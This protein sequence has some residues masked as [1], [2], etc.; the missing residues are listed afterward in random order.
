MESHGQVSAPSTNADI[1]PFEVR[2]M[3]SAISS[4]PA[5]MEES[6]AE[7]SACA[8]MYGAAHRGELQKVVEWLRKGVHVDAL[9][10]F[11]DEDD[12]HYSGALHAAAANGQLAVI[13]EMLKWGASV[14]LPNSIGATPLMMAAA[15]CGHEPSVKA[16]L[17]ANAN[18]ELRESDGR[19]ALQLA[20][21]EG[22][23][24]IAELI[25]QHSSSPQH[26]NHPTLPSTVVPSGGVAVSSSASS[27]L[28]PSAARDGT[29]WGLTL[30]QHGDALSLLC[31]LVCL[32]LAPCLLLRRRAKRQGDSKKPK[33]QYRYG[34]KKKAAGGGSGSAPPAAEPAKEEARATRLEMAAA[35]MLAAEPRLPAPHRPARRERRPRADARPY[36]C[37]R[38]YV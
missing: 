10:S 15:V 1:L 7:I 38:S 30:A 14:D 34:K 35:R 9:C 32:A 27:S 16:L 29:V 18:T 24:A 23:T 11:E 19:T 26:T 25:R 36:I 3:G 31:L 17:R 37:Q 5:P 20:E 21:D 28:P 6:C 33:K 22:N 8:E 2:T 13:K 12:S 4:A